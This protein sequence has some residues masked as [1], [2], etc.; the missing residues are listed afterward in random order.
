[1]VNLLMTTEKVME[2]TNGKMEDDMKECGKII[3]SMERGFTLI[4]KVTEPRM[5]GSMESEEAE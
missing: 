3:I 2:F 1:M 5:F 4:R